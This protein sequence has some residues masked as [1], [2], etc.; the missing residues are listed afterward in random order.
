MRSKAVSCIGAAVAT[1]GLTVLSA[2]GAAAA[3][4]ERFGID[5]EFELDLSCDGTPAHVYGTNVGTGKIRY[6]GKDGMPYFT[7]KY[8]GNVWWTNPDTGRSIR[9]RASFN[10]QDQR[11]VDNGDGT[12]TLRWRGHFNETD[13]NSDGSVAFRTQGVDT[14]MLVIDLNGTV[15]DPGDDVVLSEDYLGFT[16]HDGRAGVDFCEWYTEQTA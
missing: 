1:A 5:E 16:G 8:E 10:E 4:P 12:I 6:R 11:I 15:S 13:Y 9:L 14:V 2:P 7:L 3:A